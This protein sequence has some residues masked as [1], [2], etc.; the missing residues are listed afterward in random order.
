MS[1]RSTFSRFTRLSLTLQVAASILLAGVVAVLAIVVAERP[2]LRARFDATQSGRNSLD[3]QTVEILRDLPEDTQV[4]L[5][6]EP[7]PGP[8]GRAYDDA[9]W[10][11]RTLLTVMRG[12]VPET[13]EV[14]D[15]DLVGE[16]RERAGERLGRLG[17][18][19]TQK[20]VVS[21]GERHAVLDLE[22][23]LARL[24]PGDPARGVP[25]AVRD[26]RGEEALAEAFTRLAT[27]GRPRLAFAVGHGEYSLLPYDQDRRRVL[28][29]VSRAATDLDGEGFELVLW[30]PEVDGAVPADVDV[31]AIVG[32]TQVLP[33]AHA[34]HVQAFL[35]RGGRLLV[36]VDRAQR[37]EGDALAA[38]LLRHGVHVAPGTVNAPYMGSQQGRPECEIRTLD[39][40]RLSATHPITRS[41]RERERRLRLIGSAAFSPRPPA[42]FR[43]SLLDLLTSPEGSWRDLPEVPRGVPYLYDPA[44]EERGV[45][46][47]ALAAEIETPDG[48]PDARMV[49]LGT[50]SLMAD[51]WYRFDRD[52]V[53][54][55]F[56]WLVERDVRIRVSPRDP[57]E[58]RIDLATGTAARR[59]AWFGIAVLPGLCAVA[60][61]FTAWRRRRNV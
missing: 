13:L 34:D 5:F 23:D 24:D 55:C 40:E 28:R 21:V 9:Q 1:E 12:Y 25:A 2:S 45:F 42:P 31:L 18:D 14:V 38:L 51:G 30:D 41:L 57:F 39:S 44:L 56:N 54:N 43:G 19:A 29:S 7:V 46:S 50:P 4:E 11:T 53:R 61:L 10:R 3:A 27:S 33:E 58:S 48:V 59:S 32:P 8:L 15:H 22:L 20:V 49:V 37:L 16:G 60:G 6:F 17:L 52:F 47:L 35:D 26:F 36:A